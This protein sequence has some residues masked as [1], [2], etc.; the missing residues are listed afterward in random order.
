MEIKA[1]PSRSPEKIFADMHRELRA[2]NQQVPESPERLDPILKI[3]MRL[4][5][6]QLSL[7]DKRIDSVWEMAANSLI[8]AVCPE[9]KRWPVPSFT[10][11]RCQPGDPVVEVDPHLRFFYK[12]K[13]EGGQTFFFSPLRK[14]R[15]IAARIKHIYLT[16]GSTVMDLSP[17]PES[18]G[19]S[20][21]PLSFP[22][23]DPG[24]I[25]IGVEYEG[26]PSDLAGAV[27]FIKG[28]VEVLKQLR[29]GHWRAA[30]SSGN[31][32][33]ESRF[34][35]GLIDSLSDILSIDGRRIDW[36]G[37][38]TSRDLF[39]TLEDNFILLPRNFS[40]GWAAGPIDKELAEK[41]FTAGINPPPAGEKVYWLRI[42]LPRGG[43]K[44]KLQSSF[45]IHFNCFI[46]INKNELTLFK[47]TGGNRLVEVELP[48]DIANILEIARVVDSGGREYVPRFTVQTS[49]AQK[50]YSLEERNNKIVLWFD[51]SSDIELPPD[52][53]SVNYS[54]TAGVSGN[55]IEAAKIN[56]LYEAHPG[57]VAIENIVPTGGAVPA[58]T[59]KQI[60]NEVSARLRNRDRAMN[61]AEISNWAMTFDP[62]ILSAE[63]RNG[64]ERAARGV[65][66]CI[67]VIIRVKKD[68][69]YSDEETD[70]LERRLN[71]FLKSR[72]PINTHFKIEIVKQ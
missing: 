64:I 59:E 3:L 60:V 37:L 2:W 4:Y 29:W 66:R 28:A 31:F 67:E 44:T 14:E 65:R 13:R 72:S 48:E 35:P 40:T 38:R 43:D 19:Y 52:S 1:T 9:S 16:A 50:A 45:E 21:Q 8:R 32:L 17:N 47:H 41:M 20:R 61:F 62:R 22:A 71:S 18:T 15:L 34:C 46:A 57:I 25:F 49:R 33:E 63:C 70:L 6:H 53:I 24:K 11:M 10:V 5:A 12:E 27:L 23:T 7:I 54:I 55:G 58:K 69:F 30:D 68:G 36:G 56:E 39:K 26:I 42:D 51:F